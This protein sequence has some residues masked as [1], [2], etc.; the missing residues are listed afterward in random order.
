MNKAIIIGS[1]VVGLIVLL[2]L[3]TTVP[4]AS[5]KVTDRCPLAPEGEA[6]VRYSMLRGETVEDVENA[7]KQGDPSQGCAL[8]QTHVLYIF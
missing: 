7:T 6:T 4:I 1:I 8:K 3:I 2:V 5:R